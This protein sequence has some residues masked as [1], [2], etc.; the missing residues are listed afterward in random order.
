MPR[1]STPSAVTNA[2][3]AHNSSLSLI[4][5]ASCSRFQVKL[6]RG[7]NSLASTRLRA[8]LRSKTTKLS[9]SGLSIERQDI[10]KP[11]T[12]R[13][14]VSGKIV[15]PAAGWRYLRHQQAAPSP[16]SRF[17]Q[18]Q[19]GRFIA[20]R[21]SDNQ[22]VWFGPCDGSGILKIDH[23]IRRK[24][25]RPSRFRGAGSHARYQQRKRRYPTPRIPHKPGR[26]CRSTG[27]QPSKRDIFQA[28][29]SAPR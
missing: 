24:V 28:D 4:N 14:S 6:A 22:L 10:T 26:Y 18:P 13:L 15:D 21:A 8:V 1:M 5:P 2:T 27:H 16:A 7:G 25:G 29:Q 12:P 20:D 19:R 17:P 23:V 3:L 11:T 9:S